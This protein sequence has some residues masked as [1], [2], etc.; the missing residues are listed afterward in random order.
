M[1]KQ[2]VFNKILTTTA[3]VCSV[4]VEDLLNGR[5]KEDVVVAR[6]IMVFW[7]NAAGFT[8][9][10]LLKCTGKK[11]AN[12]IKSIE[13]MIEDYWKNKFAYHLLIK[14]VGNRLLE[15]AKSINEEFDIEK[16]IKHIAKITGK[17]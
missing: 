15:Y 17:Y 10:S 6:S 9:S 12:S 13:A 1:T 4:N 11:G 14:E 8:C 7:C 16:P 2:E 5:G 3:E